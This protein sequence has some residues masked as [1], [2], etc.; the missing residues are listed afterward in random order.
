[1][2][3]LSIRNVFLLGLLTLA[4]SL[5]FRVVRW[6]ARIRSMSKSMPVVPV[7]FPST[8]AYRMIIPKSWQTYHR[9]WHMQYGRSIYHK[10]GSDVF[11]LV[12]LF[13]KDKIFVSDP[14]GIVE[15]KATGTDRFQI[16][17]HQASQVQFTISLSGCL[18][19]MRLLFMVR[20]LLLQQDRNGNFIGKSL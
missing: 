19:T 4:T 5:L 7:L 14:A 16:D 6:L 15:L 10:H 13:E 11:A 8:S 2:D 17:L 1:M 12:S 18:L 3:S 20:T 9:D